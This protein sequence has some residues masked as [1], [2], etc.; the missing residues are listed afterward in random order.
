MDLITVNS[1]NIDQAH[2]CCAIADKKGETCV[3]SKKGWMKERFADGLTFRRLDA[4]GKVFI[5]YMPAENAWYPI[6]ADGYM[7]INCFWV[8]G[9]FKGQGHANALLD[10]CIADA[11][12]RGMRGLSVISSEKKRSFLSD[13]GYLKHRG[14]YAADTALPD[15]VLY[16]LPF[17]DGS[18]VPR[19]RSCAKTGRIDEGEM[20]LYY[21][22]QCPHTDKY[23]PLIAEM[24]QAHGAT[25]TIHK[26]TT[27]AQARNAPTPF[28]TYAFFYDGAF[29]TNE[30][31]S[32]KKF[33]KFLLEH[34][35]GR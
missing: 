15:F 31:F 13:P 27:R 26:I 2:I 30:I 14:F 29:V 16:C 21:T 1:Q 23:V 33:E 7:H 11:K 17:E 6:E 35:L 22:N 28:T 5:E 18:P 24:A 10:D 25:L 12:A 8:S 20:V 34:G 4:R 9:Q 19:F 3:S 32:E